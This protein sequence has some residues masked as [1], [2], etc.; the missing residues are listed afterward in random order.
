ML[1]V[2]GYITLLGILLF[3]LMEDTRQILLLYFCRKDICMYACV[4][5][6]AFLERRQKA[7]LQVNSTNSMVSSNMKPEQSLNLE[8]DWVCTLE[9][10]RETKF[11]GHQPRV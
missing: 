4:H 7:L 10:R 11:L 3:L 6:F 8:I 1:D 5:E 9:V 2:N